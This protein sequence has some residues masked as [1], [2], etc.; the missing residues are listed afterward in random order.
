MFIISPS[1]SEVSDLDKDNKNPL[2][3]DRNWELLVVIRLR[4]LIIFGNLKK[5]WTL[6]NNVPYPKS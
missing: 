1:Y 4:F 3:Y 5:T 2:M 6:G